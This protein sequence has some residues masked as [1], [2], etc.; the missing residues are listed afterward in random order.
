[1]EVLN[2]AILEVFEKAKKQRKAAEQK[3]Q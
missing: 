1:M 2:M 3:K